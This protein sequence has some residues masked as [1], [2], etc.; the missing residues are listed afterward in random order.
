MGS[1][2]YKS[3]QIKLNIPNKV[4]GASVSL[5]EG[6]EYWD[7]ANGDDDPWY[8]GAPSK[9]YYRWRVW[10]TVTPQ[11]H[12]SHLTRDSFV[13]NGLDIVIGD[14]IAGSTTGLCVKVVSILFK[15]TSSVTCIVEDY[16]RYNTFRQPNGNGIFGPGAAVVFSLNENGIPML[17]PL[18]D[19]VSSDF[20]TTVTSRFN[21]LNPALNYV[22]YQPNHSLVRGDVVAVTASGFS[23]ANTTTMD[24]MIGVVT[25]SGPGPDYFIISPN[26]RI[27]DFD[28]SIPGNQGDY[29]YVSETGNLTTEQSKKVVFLK[30]QDAIPTVLQG[31]VNNPVLPAG[32]TIQIN[33]V[34]IT[35]T[36]AGNVNV[37]QIAASINTETDSHQV[38]AEQ[39]PV[40]TAAFGNPANTAYGT[41]GGYTPFS[42]YFDT[43]SGNTL[44]NFTSSGSQFPGVSS[45]EDIK[46]DILAA[47]IPNVDVLLT[48]GSFVLLENNGN[49]ISIYNNTSDQNGYAFAGANSV[50]GLALFTP[51]TQ[52]STRLRLT[53]SDGGEILI[54]EDTEFFR[55][56]TGIASGHTGMYPL[57]MNIEAGLRTGGVT[58]VANIAAR[59]SLFPQTG[60][61]AYVLNRGNGEWALYL[62]SGTGWV[63]V[64]NADSATTDAK[65]LTTTFTMPVSGNGEV[66][67]QNMGSIS[68][69]RKILSITVTVESVFQN[70]SQTPY[71]EVGTDADPALF[72]GASS[73]H[74]TEATT[75]QQN[76]DYVHPANSS[77]DL[78]V[79]ARCYHYDADVGT[80][81]VKLTYV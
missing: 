19:T 79:K 27:I 53:R 33:S 56:N 8:A 68:P 40:P 58:V 45:V 41:V 31:R 47:N 60:D 7:F 38:V 34:P 48:G 42:A 46:S 11:Q 76:P 14:W 9:R 69:G 77:E 37:S 30:V 18:P 21:Y 71:I 80:A 12:G 50:S 66:T 70:H 2:N 10:F 54:Y 24:R 44:I 17:D 29:V 15:T 64:S 20:Y 26:N 63:E 13:Y 61:Q 59:D 1:I 4:L 62:Y 28:P 3:S 43:G 25:D 51:S 78:L 49:S 6:L 57:A 35:F 81:V 36:G 22:L 72:I 23:K 67:V 52:P 74:L 5:V 32:H 73:N 16:L 55:V 39:T 75:F 65:T